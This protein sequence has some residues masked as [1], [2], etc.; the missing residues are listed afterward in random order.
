M[1]ENKNQKEFCNP[2]SECNCMKSI[3]NSLLSRSFDYMMTLCSFTSDQLY[4]FL[5]MFQ[6][7]VL[8]YNYHILLETNDC[9]QKGR[10]RN[11]T[12]INV[13]TAMNLKLWV[14][15]VPPSNRR[16]LGVKSCSYYFGRVLRSWMHFLKRSLS[17]AF[18]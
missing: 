9:I 11:I 3:I 4:I 5:F 18:S 12:Q 6:W 16:E 13:F 10:N 14:H 8:K 1:N 2:M 15:I 17:Q 7:E